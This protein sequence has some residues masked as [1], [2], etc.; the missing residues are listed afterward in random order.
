MP[1]IDDTLEDLVTEVVPLSEY[2]WAYRYPG[3]PETPDLEE[4]RRALLI[5]QKAYDAIL[6]RIPK[7]THL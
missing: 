2:A 6:H 3:E 5:A 1:K 4:S 7:E